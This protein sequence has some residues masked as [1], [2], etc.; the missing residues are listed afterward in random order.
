MEKI[1]AAVDSD[2]KSLAS[3][4]DIPEKISECSENDSAGV[5]A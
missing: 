5:E 4:A 2:S 1:P 3:D